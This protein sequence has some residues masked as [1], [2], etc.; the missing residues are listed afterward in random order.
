MC[1]D[2]RT[3]GPQGHVGRNGL[4]HVE[5]PE[6]SLSSARA[7]CTFVIIPAPLVPPD[8]GEEFS[9]HPCHIE[10]SPETSLVG[11]II[12][13]CSSPAPPGG[14]GRGR[15]GLEPGRPPEPA[16]AAAM[17][18]SLRQGISAR[19][20][21]GP[22]CGLTCRPGPVGCTCPS[23]GILSGEPGAVEYLLSLPQR[24]LPA[25]AVVTPGQ[26]CSLISPPAAGTR[27]T[28][29]GGT[30]PQSGRHTCPDEAQ[31]RAL[32]SELPWKPQRQGR[33]GFQVDGKGT[34]LRAHTC[35][36]AEPPRAG[37]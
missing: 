20:R 11:P 25:L 19:H 27:I 4:V 37:R 8:T 9:L 34:W 30:G 12:A 16:R 28:F 18:Q 5:P 10:F 2:A 35:R 3:P 13:P 33:G 1:V 6:Q 26:T 7:V 36:D 17:H 29:P 21:A 23:G 22:P 31:T 14:G 24:S 15:C 32:G